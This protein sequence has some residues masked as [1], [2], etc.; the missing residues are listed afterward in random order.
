MKLTGV[1]L[2]RVRMPLVAP[3]RTSF[4]SQDV[5]DLVLVRVVTPAAEGWGECGAMAAPVYSPEYVDGVDHVLRTYLV[6][7]L[8]AAGELTAN[9]VG[10]L[11]AGVKGHRMAKSALEM[12]VL[13]AE[14]RAHGTSFATALGSTKDVVPCGVSVGIADSVPRLLDEV[15]GYLAAGYRRIKLKIE[16]GWDVE[17]VRAVRERFGDILLQVDAN[18]AYTLSDVPQLQR[19]DPFELLLIEQPLDEEDVLGH[20]ELARH[21]RTPICLDESVVSARSAADAIRL[22]ACRIVNIKPSRVGGYLE[23]RRVHDVCVAHGIPVWCGGMLESG[24][25]RAAN[26]ALASLPGFTLPGDT[27]ASGRFYR[28]DI[29]DPFVLDDGC[30]PVPSGPGLGVAPIPELLAEV[31]GDRTWLAAP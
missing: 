29:T 8:L 14:L 3:F 25:G 9:K 12:A 2:L 6:P 28:T 5:R 27:S 1:E 19:L 4:G 24:L 18:T 15:G 30:L 20:A 17:P 7:L 10:P 22:G 16:P 21:L 13:D 26:V 23:A 31:T 11:L